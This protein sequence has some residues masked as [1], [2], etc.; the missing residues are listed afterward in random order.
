MKIKKEYLILF[1]LIVALSLYLVLHQRDRTH[2]KLPEIPA[3]P[4]SEITR[5]EI[6]KPAGTIRLEKK[7]EKWVI[8]PEAYPA[9]ANKVQAMLDTL[10]TLTLTALVSESKSYA[11]YDLQEGRKIA[12]RAWAGE[13]L[14]REF[15]VGKVA[16]S[17]RHTFVKLAADDRVYHA[18]A[19]FRDTFDQTVENLRDRTVLRFDQKEIQKVEIS[20]GK[21]ALTLLRQSVPVELSAGQG[22]DVK[23][24]EPPR[25][26]SLWQSSEGEKVDEGK[27]KGLMSTLSSLNCSAYMEGR[28]KEEFTEPVYTIQL[29]GIKRYRLAVFDKTDKEDKTRPAVSSE[30]DF[31]FL[32]TDSQ[33]NRIMIP[34][35]EILKKPGESQ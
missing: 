32:L 8:E 22:G 26:E 24:T 7:E 3:V 33:A 12:V 11:R 16:P 28:K 5:I 1:I 23:G 34:L 30:N 15:D 20:D 25:M 18:R 6:Q 21:T 10:G 35:E 29:E 31:P 17:F 27:L 19:N 9:D 14:R 13:S 2:Y 4:K